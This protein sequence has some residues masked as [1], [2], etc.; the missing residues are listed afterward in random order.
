MKT[1]I[2][3]INDAVVAHLRT[4]RNTCTHLLVGTSSLHSTVKQQTCLFG[5]SVHGHSWK[6]FPPNHQRVLEIVPS[7]FGRRHAR[8]HIQCCF[9][10]RAAM[11]FSQSLHLILS[12]RVSRVVAYLTRCISSLTRTFHQI[13]S[14]HVTAE[15]TSS[16]VVL[17]TKNTRAA[18]Q[19]FFSSF[20]SSWSL[21]FAVH[22]RP[23]EDITSVHSQY[24]FRLNHI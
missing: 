19:D 13:R 24:S 5:K 20:L 14:Y 16:E 3:P 7:L 10:R 1:D 21:H 22:H 11:S 15:T 9:L 12:V 23:P 4:G 2:A 17:H 18:L 8:H 6:V